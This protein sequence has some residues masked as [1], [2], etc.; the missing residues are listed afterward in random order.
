MLLSLETGI[1][2]PSRGFTEERSAREFLL[3]NDLLNRLLRLSRTDPSR[4]R[5]PE[6]RPPPEEEFE[7]VFKPRPPPEVKPRPLPVRPGVFSDR[8]FGRRCVPL[9]D[10]ILEIGEGP[11]SRSSSEMG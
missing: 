1:L 10:L 5:E 11:L 4:P 7:E 6:V 8:E 2:N 3:L 9:D